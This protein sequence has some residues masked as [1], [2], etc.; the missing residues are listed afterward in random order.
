MVIEAI[1]FQV[2]INWNQPAKPRKNKSI[3]KKIQTCFGFYR[4]RFTSRPNLQNFTNFLCA[5]TYMFLLRSCSFSW[6]LIIA[7][8][9][10]AWIEAY[11]YLSLLIK[12]CK[13]ISTC[14]FI[15]IYIYS[16]THIHSYIY[17]FS[18][19]VIHIL[20]MFPIHDASYRAITVLGQQMSQPLSFTIS[21]LV[22]KPSLLR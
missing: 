4:S 11:K 19:T 18:I 3:C 20:G 8:Y 21:W 7:K 10:I 6:P 1:Y 22:G 15:Y 12:C 5:A 16:H 14:R 13:C 17:T 9:C 2:A